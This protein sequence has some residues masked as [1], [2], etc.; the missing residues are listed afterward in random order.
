M[1]GTG[2]T[3]PYIPLAFPD[4]ADGCSVLIRNPQLMPTSLMEKAASM[5][6]AD[7]GIAIEAMTEILTSLIVAWRN[8]YPVDEDLSDVDL[9]GE[10]SI[11]DLAVLLETR[12]RQPLGP[13]S[14]DTVPRIPMTITLAITEHIKTGTNPQ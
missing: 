9:H 11:E 14:P 13:P 5:A 3:N 4:L 2:Y 1:T 10:T 12:Q 7:G 8:V 6:S